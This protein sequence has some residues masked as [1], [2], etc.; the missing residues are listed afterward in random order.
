MQAVVRTSH[1]DVALSVRD[2]KHGQLM[3]VE[4][5]EVKV[6]VQRQGATFGVSTRAAADTVAAS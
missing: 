2:R 3:S 1:G 4:G 6:R 5:R